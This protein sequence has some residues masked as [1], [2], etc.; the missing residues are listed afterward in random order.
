MAVFITDADLE[1]EVAIEWMPGVDP[2][3]YSYIRQRIERTRRRQG[4]PEFHRDGTLLG[5]G[6]LRAAAD[7]RFPD[8]PHKWLRR[9]F[10]LNNNDLDANPSG[11]YQVG[12]PT[13]AIVP[14]TVSIG[15]LGK[16]PDEVAAQGAA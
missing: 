16:H 4:K 6:N 14:G 15:V 1:D 2:T 9:V 3:R 7:P 13:E 8:S 5:W 10:Y 11:P 12:T